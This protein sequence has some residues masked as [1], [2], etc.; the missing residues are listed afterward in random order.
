[1]QD[2]INQLDKLTQSATEAELLQ[3]LNKIAANTSDSALRGHFRHLLA[4]ER[5]GNQ[6]ALNVMAAGLFG[7][8]L[9]GKYML[10]ST[11]DGYKV[12][13][14]LH[15]LRK[16]M[17]ACPLLRDTLKT[18]SRLYNFYPEFYE[19]IPNLPLRV[20]ALAKAHAGADFGNDLLT[21]LYS[22]GGYFSKD[23][24]ADGLRDA[25]KVGGTTCVMTARGIYHAAGA[26]MLTD[27]APSVGTP[28]G[29]QLELG[30]PVT[31]TSNTGN[32]Y[33]AASLM[34]DDQIVFGPRGF[35][36]DNA[37]EAN[38]PKLNIGDIYFVDGDGDFKY[39]LRAQ[40]SVAAHVGIVVDNRGGKFVDTI[41]G[42]SGTGAKIDL[43]LNRAVKFVSGLGWTLDRPGRSF[44]SSNIAEVEA[45]MVQFNTKEA[46][47]AWM[48]KNPGAAKGIL[49]TY[50]RTLKDINKN[51]ANTAMVKMLEKTLAAQIEA[52]RKLI[53]VVKQ[54]QNT[55]GQDRVLKGWWKPERYP[56]L[57]YAGRDLLKSWLTAQ[58]ELINS[59][60]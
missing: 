45:Y 24:A 58:P 33:A 41:D 50:N 15:N 5:E 57:N 49:D 59:A 16:A 22:L 27:R 31:H 51:S 37:D 18:N 32:R 9:G 39:L 19:S 40:L 2:I 55:L 12:H 8:C 29:P 43:N 38:R 1:M 23:E 53:R 4:N 26:N 28:G 25:K 10:A 36:D 52:G 20:A 14:F 11:A 54:G 56:E 48:Q 35:N 30:R 7:I 46:V 60:A 47:L 34:R 13:P 17:L 44:T 42:G 3:L 6:C 21:V